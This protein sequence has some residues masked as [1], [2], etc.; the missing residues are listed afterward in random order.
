MIIY[1]I[2][3]SWFLFM[4]EFFHV[5]YKLNQV[6]LIINFSLFH[7]ESNFIIE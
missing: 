6:F 1:L 3:Y 2:V 4:Y 5:F 7:M